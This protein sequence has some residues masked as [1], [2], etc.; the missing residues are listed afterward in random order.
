MRMRQQSEALELGELVADG[1]R[2]DAHPRPLDEILGADGL[3][4]GD[5]LLDDADQDLPLPLTEIW[6]WRNHVRCREMLREKLHGDASTEEAPPLR[7]GQRL[8]AGPL[9]ARGQPEPL[10]PAQRTA[11]QRGLQPRKRQRLVQAQPQQQ[12]LSPADVVTE[13]LELP[14]RSPAGHERR[15]VRRE[16]RG[17]PPPQ[18][19]DCR[20]RADP[21]A[22]IIPPE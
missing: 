11:V 7:Q 2:R 22:K 6:A 1:C 8:G 20:Y 17:V 12:P 21:K 10:E 9:T 15:K 18:A 3:P 14:R 13:R 4:R 19:L 16:P 5:V